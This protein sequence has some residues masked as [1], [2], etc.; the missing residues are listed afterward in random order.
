MREAEAPWL[1]T[2]SLV[3]EQRQYFSHFGGLIVQFRS[4]P[5]IRQREFKSG[6]DEIT[7]SM[8]FSSSQLGACILTIMTGLWYR[9]TETIIKWPCGSDIMLVTL[10]SAFLWI[11]IAVPRD[12]EL[13]LEWKIWPTHVFLMWSLTIK[14]VSCKK[15]TS[16]FKSLRCANILARFTGP[17]RPLTFHEINLTFSPPVFWLISCV[18]FMVC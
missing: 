12:R 6:I 3:H 5:K 7:F 13:K 1:K 2:S 15:A 14:R 4:P 11:I 8:N 10:K 17:F 16:H 18:L 9:D